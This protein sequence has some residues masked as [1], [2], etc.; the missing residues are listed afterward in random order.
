MNKDLNNIF[1]RRLSQA[2]QMMGMSM[3]ELGKSLN[4]K[5]SRQ[6]INKYEKGHTSPDSRMLIAFGTVLGVKPD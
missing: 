6:A 3:E 2:R 5:M 1:G 4:P